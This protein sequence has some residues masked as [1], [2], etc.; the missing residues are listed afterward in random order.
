MKPARSFPQAQT[1]TA[2]VDRP[3]VAVTGRRV[4]EEQQEVCST[5]LSSTTHPGWQSDDERLVEDG[6][7]AG[8]GSQAME[9]RLCLPVAHW[10]S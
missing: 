5:A 3:T 10:H 6:H 7:P 9:S 8:R 2:R 4:P 1:P